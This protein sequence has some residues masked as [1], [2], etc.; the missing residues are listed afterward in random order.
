MNDKEPTTPQP[1]PPAG[2]AR[3]F[4][5]FVI[6]PA[7]GPALVLAAHIGT[8]TYTGG[9]LDTWRFDAMMG[10]LLSIIP[11]YLI[12]WLIGIPAHRYARRQTVTLP[13]WGGL[14]L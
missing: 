11:G 9:F 4:W 1:P 12:A 7:M 14:L 3:T 10:G 8:E 2:S 6:S 13:G 5:A